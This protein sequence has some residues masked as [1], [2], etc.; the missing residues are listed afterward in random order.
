M[1]LGLEDGLTILLFFIGIIIVIGAQIRISSSY[2]KF[3][4]ISNKKNLTGQEV[5]R[6]ILDA[7]GLNNI[8]VVET[9]GE[10]TDHYDPNRKVIKLSR[11]IFNKESIAAISV[12]AHEV[13]HA[14]QD[15]DGYIYMRIRAFLVPVV[16]FVTYIGYI[17]AFISLF[18]GITGYLKVSIFIILAAILFQLITLP[19]EFDASKRA[20]EELLKLNLIDSNEAD[21]VKDM[22][23]A[24]AMTYVASLI[25]SLINLLRLIIMLRGRDD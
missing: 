6:M 14:I 22:L 5:A 25:S 12:A 23:G 7:N 24:A 18:A 4:K 17:V 20:K 1:Y 3:D 13:G 10:L 8:Y 19:V 21:N 16:N 15:K 9:E 2:K 11:G